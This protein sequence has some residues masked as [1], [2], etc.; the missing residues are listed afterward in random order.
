MIRWIR[1]KFGTRYVILRMKESLDGGHTAGETTY[2][3]SWS[4]YKPTPF[5]RIVNLFKFVSTFMMS[6]YNYLKRP[7]RFPEG[8][9]E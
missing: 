8:P 5:S 4:Y 3:M 9:N 6:Y 1:S 2:V 7:K